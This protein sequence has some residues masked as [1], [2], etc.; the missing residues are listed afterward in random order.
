MLTCHEPAASPRVPGRLAEACVGAQA[1]GADVS[2]KPAASAGARKPGA[3]NPLQLGFAGS[4][5][6]RPTVRYRPKYQLPGPPKGP[7]NALLWLLGLA[8]LAVAAWICGQPATAGF[9]HQN[10]LRLL[11]R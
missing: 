4:K 6:H 9:P 8:G 1:T 3:Q 11:Q 5:M 7:S 2:M 10:Q